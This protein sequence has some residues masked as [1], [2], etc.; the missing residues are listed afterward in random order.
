M[1]PGRSKYWDRSHRKPL[2]SLK[3]RFS[4]TRLREPLQ[5]SEDHF[6]SL[7]FVRRA[8]SA[9]FG[10]GLFSDPAWDILLELYAARLGK[11]TMSLSELARAIETPLSTT[12]RWVVE[13]EGRGLIN[14]TAG[15]TDPGP[16]QVELTQDASSKLE[17]LG[18]HWGSAFVSI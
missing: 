13:L 2:E 10:T 4:G 8:R 18:D 3:S 11:R 7:I 9:V 15:T 14:V 1:L 12:K 16:A 17:H 5:L 6:L